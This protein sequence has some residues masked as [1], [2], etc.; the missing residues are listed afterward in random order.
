M[1]LNKLNLQS[2]SPEGSPQSLTCEKSI[3]F[4]YLTGRPSS[5]MEGLPLGFFHAQQL[6][7]MSPS[8]VFLL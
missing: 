5:L 2:L 4:V 3:F 1:N 7:Q 6:Q 8:L